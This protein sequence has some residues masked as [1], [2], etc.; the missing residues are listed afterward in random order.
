MINYNNSKIYKIEPVNGEDGDIY[1]GSTT[2][3]LLSQRMT[4]HRATYKQWKNDNYNWVS[5]FDIF[6]K[7]GLENCNIYLIESYECSTRD[8][9]R[10]REGHFIKSLN[11]VNKRLAGRSRKEY[12]NEYNKINK[13]ILNLKKREQYQKNKDMKKEYYQQN[14]DKIKEYLKEY[15]EN[16]KEKIKEQKK[17]YNK[18]RCY[19]ISL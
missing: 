7:Y 9:L 17:E 19:K 11:C 15:R 10:A 1:I 16:N 12:Q 5:V 6:D 3:S 18:R 2:K 8:E 4:S 13:D 14:K